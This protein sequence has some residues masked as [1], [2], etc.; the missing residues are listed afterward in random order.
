[1][2]LI[3]ALIWCLFHPSGDSIPIA[4]N[5][6]YLYQLLQEQTEDRLLESLELG[7]AD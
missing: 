7:V 4:Q 5:V 3:I 6:E 1:M 2:K